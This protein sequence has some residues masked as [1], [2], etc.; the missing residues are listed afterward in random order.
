MQGI[1]FQ[2]IF[3]PTTKPTTIRMLMQV[4]VHN[5]MTVSQMDVKTAYLNVDIDCEIFM[6]QPQGFVETNEKGET[7]V[8]KLKKSLYGLK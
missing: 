7:L 5:N 6:E 8:C 4:V 2:E 1:D 3:S